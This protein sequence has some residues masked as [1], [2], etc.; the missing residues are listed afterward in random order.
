[1]E[2]LSGFIENI[3]RFLVFKVT[4]RWYTDD[5]DDEILGIKSILELTEKIIV[6]SALSWCHGN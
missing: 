2:N 6:V 3:I 5:D 1:M 4:S